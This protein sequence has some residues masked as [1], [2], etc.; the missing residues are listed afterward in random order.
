MKVA[1][2]GKERLSRKLSGISLGGGPLL[3][4]MVEYALVPFGH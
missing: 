1:T 2:K 4:I 3:R